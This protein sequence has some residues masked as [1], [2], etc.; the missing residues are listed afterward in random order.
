VGN[1]HAGVSVV[2]DG[3]VEQDDAVVRVAQ[4]KAKVA[5]CVCSAARLAFGDRGNKKE[6]KKDSQRH[7][8]TERQRQRQRETETET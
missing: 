5:K 6:R 2:Y 7:R 3:V 1:L 4:P 8:E